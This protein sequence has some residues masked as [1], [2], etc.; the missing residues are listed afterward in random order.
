[1][2][3]TFLLNVMS[4]E[5]GLNGILAAWITWRQ[6]IQLLKKVLVMNFEHPGVSNFT[7]YFSKVL[8]YFT[9]TIFKLDLGWF[10]FVSVCLARKTAMQRGVQSVLTLV[11][12]PPDIALHYIFF[13]AMQHGIQSVLTL[14]KR[15]PDVALHFFSFLLEWC[16][17]PLYYFFFSILSKKKLTLDAYIAFMEQLGHRGDE[18]AL[19]LPGVM[20]QIHYFFFSIRENIE[21]VQQVAQP[22]KSNIAL[23]FSFLL[24]WS[25]GR[26]VHYCTPKNVTIQKHLHY[27]TPKNFTIQKPCLSRILLWI[28]KCTCT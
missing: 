22:F 18:L 1:M 6:S 28:S 15:P 2:R 12:R 23:F 10:L 5:R 17:E 19:H 8:L 24:T 14:V 26:W 3:S 21:K 20:N 27:C 9:L 16:Y 13:F 11:K 25:Q 4:V 7:F